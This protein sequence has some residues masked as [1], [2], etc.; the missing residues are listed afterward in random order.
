[1]A[2]ESIK[3]H[4][5][6]DLDDTQMNQN[7][8]GHKPDAQT[9]T[10]STQSPPAIIVTAPTVEAPAAGAQTPASAETPQ[11]TSN[12]DALTKGPVVEI[13][14]V[15]Y[16]EYV[17]TTVVT[18]VPAP[19]AD[20]YYHFLRRQL[21]CTGYHHDDGMIELL[22]V[23]CRAVKACLDRLRVSERDLDFRVVN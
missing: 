6:V 10:H 13:K 16:S 8:A 14:T 5:A 22:R 7:S 23:S 17:T 4:A 1:M 12:S 18:G 20:M 19:C 9:H 11:A 21:Q 2:N 15:R 3:C